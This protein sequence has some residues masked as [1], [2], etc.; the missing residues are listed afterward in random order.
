M[1]NVYRLDDLDPIEKA[2]V[3][4]TGGTQGVWVPAVLVRMLRGDGNAAL[5][6]AQLVFWSNGKADEEGWFWLTGAKLK[7]QSGL[8]DHAQRRAFAKLEQLGLLEKK[9]GGMPRRRYFRLN[10]TRCLECL[11]ASSGVIP[12]NL[13]AGSA[14][15]QAVGQGHGA[16]KQEQPA[17]ETPPKHDDADAPP[18]EET[19]PQAMTEEEAATWL[20]ETKGAWQAPENRP[21]PADTV[22]PI[23]PEA[24]LVFEQ[25]GASA[26]AAGNRVP[27]RFHTLQQKRKFLAA[28]ERLGDEF[29]RALQVALEEGLN[30][31]RRI[32]DWLAKWDGRGPRRPGGDGG[33]PSKPPLVDERTPEQIAALAEEMAA[34]RRRIEEERSA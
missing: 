7:E 15:E 1:A 33:P 3:A 11:R 34:H 19:P 4:G 20:E 26:K 16:Y 12:P 9:L 5:V 10:L 14:E 24:V 22:F 17:V 28:V 18:P 31:V 32:T 21:P 27:T 29:P 25:L 2:A 13:S 6:W 8:G 30:S 23:I